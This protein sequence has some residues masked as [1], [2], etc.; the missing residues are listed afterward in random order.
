VALAGRAG[1]GLA[2]SRQ[3]TSAMHV[4]LLPERLYGARLLATLDRL[5]AD[6]A[7]GFAAIDARRDAQTLPNEPLFLPTPTAN[8]PA[9]GQWYLQAPSSTPMTV[10]GV[11]TT[12]LAATDAVSAWNLTTRSTGIVIA[13]LDHGGGAR[14]LPDRR[15]R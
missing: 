7:V 4:L 3:L 13:D 2:G 12:D 11:S 15:L 10:A 9:S 1:I 5:R 14:K 8:P 6:P